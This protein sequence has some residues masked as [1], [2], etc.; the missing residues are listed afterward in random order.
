MQLSIQCRNGRTDLV[1]ASTALAPR[2]EGYAVTYDAKDGKPPVALPFGLPPSGAGL[3]IRGDVVRLL[4]SLP[5]QGE[6][7]FRVSG[8]GVVVEGSYGLAALKSVLGRM[9]RPCNWQSPAGTTGKPTSA[10]RPG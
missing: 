7:L 1:I 8:Q 4:M 2:A 5:A 3:A 6:V 9:T 10:G